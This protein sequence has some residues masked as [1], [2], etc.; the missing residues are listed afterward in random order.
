MLPDHIDQV[1]EIETLS[2][3]IPWTRRAFFFELT[4]NDFAFYIV[5]VING[6]V[7]G[8][9]GMWLVLD[10]A[11]ITNVAMHPDYRG[12]GNGRALLTEL[13]TRAAVLGAVRISLEVRVSNR[14]ARDLYRSVGFI[15]MGTRRKY[16]SDND[17]DAIIMC[18][19]MPVK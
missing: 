8:Y 19:N 16:Y 3:P 12:N 9:A 1:I 4:E 13:L 17:E 15:D 2:F 10:E 5:A 7:V 6:R 18:L 14:A 11:H